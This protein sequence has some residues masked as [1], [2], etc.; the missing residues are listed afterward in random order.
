MKKQFK[1]IFSVIMVLSLLVS[2]FSFNVGAASVTASGG[3]YEVGQK[4]KVSI[5]YK[6]DAALYGVEIKA[7]YNSSVLRLDSVSGISASDLQNSNGT[8]KFIDDNFSNGSSSGSYTL[9]FTAI[10]AGNSNVTVSAVGSDGDSE[11]PASTTAAITVITPKPSSNANL[12]SIKLSSGSLS[13]AFNANTTNYTATVKYSVDSITITGA[14]AD[15]GA[16]YTGGGTFGLQVGD[17]QRVLTV[18]AADGSKKSYTVNIKRM[19]EQ[20]TADAEQA[21]RDADPLLVIIDGVDY[22]IVNNLEGVSLPAGFTQGTATRKDSEI[23]VLND[24]S[25]KYQLCWLTDAEGE[26]GA[27]Y[28]RDQEDNFKKLIYVNANGKMYIVEDF[29]DYGIL[30][31]NFKLSKCNLDGVGIDAIAYMDEAL[32]D[33]YVLNC[34]VGGETGYYRID[35]AEGTM[36]RA[37]DFESALLVANTE[38]QVEEPTG[39]FAWFTAMTKMGKT[40]FVVIVAVAAILVALAVILIVKIVSSNSEERFDDEINSNA[41][42]F[43]L[44]DFADDTP[45]FEPQPEQAVESGEEASQED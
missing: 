6:G 19:T 33:F 12:A 5:S 30:P 15:G 2:L 9:N 25:E 43:I 21:A 22:R 38:P 4:V 14:V 24:D 13:P 39:P 17:N 3:N 18:T 36:Q 41:N 26:N 27:F 16:T 37:V 44:N 10:S 45:D 34:Y 8:V 1:A 11:F 32:K 28:S 7:S 42:E 31:T 20:E 23:T 29:D 40:V 35:M